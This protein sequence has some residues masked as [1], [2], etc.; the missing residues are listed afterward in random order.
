MNARLQELH[1]RTT[2]LPIPAIAEG[3]GLVEEEA[4]AL[5]IAPVAYVV[6]WDQPY[7]ARQIAEAVIARYTPNAE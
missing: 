6:G 7:G 5:G 4:K 1:D 2:D 3:I